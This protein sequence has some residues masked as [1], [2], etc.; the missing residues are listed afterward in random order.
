M[1]HPQMVAKVHYSRLWPQGVK[2]PRT[3]YW[4]VFRFLTTFE[5]GIWGK[6][7]DVYTENLRSGQ[8]FSS[9]LCLFGLKLKTRAL[10]GVFFSSFRVSTFIENHGIFSKWRHIPPFNLPAPSYPK[11]FNIICNLLY[12]DMDNGNGFHIGISSILWQSRT[13]I[14]W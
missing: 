13:S 9:I 12:G 4:S 10:H 7:S 1:C 11:S 5:A 6:W 14:Y 3:R 2:I 8:H